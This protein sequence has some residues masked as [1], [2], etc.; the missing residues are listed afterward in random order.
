LLWSSTGE[1]IQNHDDEKEYVK[2]VQQYAVKLDSIVRNEDPGRYSVMAM[3]M[4]NEYDKYHIADLPKISAFNVYSGWYSGKFEEFGASLKK[5]HQEHPKEILFISEYGAGADRR[6]N[7]SEPV[8]LDFSGQYQRM[9]LESY[10]RQTREMPWL[11][12]TAIWNQFDF[13]QPNIGGTIPNLNQKGLVNWNRT[14]KDSYFL[15]KANWNPEPMIYIASRDWKQR[16]GEVSQKS[17]VE[18][19]SNLKAVTLQLNGKKIAT[20]KPD[21]VQKIVYQLSLK[22]GNNF[23][24]VTGF[25]GESAISDTLTINFKPVFITGNNF[26]SLYV[27]IGSK[28]QYLNADGILWTEDQAYKKG[29]FGHIGGENIM[30]SLKKVITSTSDVPLYYSSLEGLVCYKVDVPDGTYQINLGFVEPENL[31]KGDRVFGVSANGK[32]ILKN[33]DITA[34]AG[35][36]SALQKTFVMAVKNK[37]GLTL[38]FES[39]KGKTLLSNLSVKKITEKTA[40]SISNIIN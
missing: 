39:I 33:L 12:G 26:K 10:I 25:D 27:N 5:R 4:S 30:M 1:R 37:E 14:L 28:A 23:I 22:Q 38:N 11:S 3:H 2:H 15:F 34:E 16:S 18:V 32:S 9:F 24:K 21:D 19:Y 8:R 20:K 36:A 7:T 40:A 13:S 35:G 31:H 29:E 17:I 6:I